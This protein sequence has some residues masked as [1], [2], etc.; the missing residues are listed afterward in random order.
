MKVK[1]KKKKSNSLDKCYFN[2]VNPLAPYLQ[3]PK[4]YCELLSPEKIGHFS[5]TDYI[6]PK[7]KKKSFSKLL[8]ASFHC[9]MY[10]LTL[11]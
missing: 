5:A 11:F 10:T 2:S 7:T 8:W 3:D 4:L 6:I 1:K 9:S